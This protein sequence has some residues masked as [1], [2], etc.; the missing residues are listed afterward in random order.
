MMPH[1]QELKN[2]LAEIEK[3]FS[4][5]R[6]ALAKFKAR[7]DENIVE[8][9]DKQRSDLVEKLSKMNDGLQ[10]AVDEVMS[11]HPHAEKFDEKFDIRDGKVVYMDGIS[12]SGSRQIFIP[13]FIGVVEGPIDLHYIE[14]AEGLNFPDVVRGF[15]NLSSIK[16]AE[17]LNLP[18]TVE[19]HL[20]LRSIK[21]MKGV[22]LPD[23]VQGDIS[24]TSLQSVEGLNLPDT[25][26]GA[27]C[28]DSLTE[29]KRDELK[30]EYPRLADKI[31]TLPLH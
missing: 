31:T 19:G 29:K 21:S 23:T 9:L 3:E 7:G 11:R 22:D 15:I 4:E 10:G 16:S 28:L 5:V 20:Y 2:K 12:Y 30:K 8:V 14:S 24:M 1:C 17:D 26:R 27:I 6:D 13:S 18:N 25:V